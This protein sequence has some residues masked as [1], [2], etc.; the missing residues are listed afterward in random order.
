M[1][2]ITLFILLTVFCIQI[3]AQGISTPR[4]KIHSFNSNP[5]T[6]YLDI[7]ALKDNPSA[8]RI[9]KYPANSVAT[10]AVLLSLI[11]N[12]NSVPST[13][14]IFGY[15]TYLNTISTSPFIFGNNI[16][17][18]KQP[19]NN[20]TYGFNSSTFLQSG[21]GG[22]TYGVKAMINKQTVNTTIDTT[23]VGFAIY[24]EINHN[25][26]DLPNY[27][28]GY[29]GGKVVIA[30]DLFTDS[31]TYIIQPDEEELNVNVSELNEKLNRLSIRQNLNGRNSS[32]ATPYLFN[33]K[34]LG[35]HF[36][37]LTKEVMLVD[38]E[39]ELRKVK[40]ETAIDYT[41]FIPLLVG[42]NN[43]RQ[44]ELEESKKEIEELKESVQE[45]E[46]KIELL[47]SM[48]LE[49]NNSKEN[50]LVEDFIEVNIF[51]N[52]AENSF[53]ILLNSRKNDTVKIH[54]F[55]SEGRKIAIVK[56]DISEGENYIRM[57]CENWSAGT[58]LLKLISN[59]N[60]EISHK[61]IVQ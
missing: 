60:Q 5:D 3:N 56:K 47:S 29:F 2:K 8:L 34:E 59:N 25:L 38:K 16:S 28:A 22:D 32:N 23:S 42:A 17:I 9:T 1:K 27:F 14:N 13:L 19:Q 41:S 46:R 31:G 44:E 36:P 51:P 43:M 7:L 45:L 4:L 21:A 53:S 18:I 15:N 24:G 10:Q 57:D 50:D 37:E 35:K 39:S 12:P 49:N 26:N 33:A 52:P 61:I 40:K 30:G 6:G 48:L 55:N 58:Y 54:A 11:D 20:Y